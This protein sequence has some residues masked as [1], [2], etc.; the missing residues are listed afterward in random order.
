MK[1][2]RF[3]AE[4]PEERKSKSASKAYPFLPWTVATMRKFAAEGVQVN[5]V[6]LILDEKPYVQNGNVLQGAVTAVYATTDSPCCYGS[7]G[8]EY[9]RKRCV[10]I[11]AELVEK[12]HPQLAAYVNED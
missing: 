2:Y 12:L 9:L 10:R 1:G 3:F 6:A 11:P 5:C 7:V 4:M 8:F